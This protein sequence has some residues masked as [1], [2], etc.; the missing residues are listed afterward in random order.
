M[1]WYGDAPNNPLSGSATHNGQQFPVSLRVK[2]GAS[3]HPVAYAIAP[4][5]LVI[6]EP[7]SHVIVSNTGTFQFAYNLTGSIGETLTAGAHG[8]NFTTAIITTADQ[9][10]VKLDINPSAWTGA[11]AVVGDVTFV[12][13]KRRK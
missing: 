10:A 13:S 2:N 4:T 6:Y 5:P 3:E 9:G 8:H 1:A 7:P 11:G 12:Y